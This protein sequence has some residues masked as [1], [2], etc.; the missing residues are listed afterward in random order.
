MKYDQ[1]KIDQAALALLFINS[2]EENPGTTRSWKSLD[3]DI[4]DRLHERGLIGN[5]VGKAKSLTLNPKGI[6]LARKIAND[7]FGEAS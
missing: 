7:L 1:E 4:S 3:W 5:P 2:W 6:E